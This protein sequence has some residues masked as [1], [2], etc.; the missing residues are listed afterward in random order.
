M[1]DLKRPISSIFYLIGV[2]AVFFTQIYD[3]SGWIVIINYGLLA[4]LVGLLI[5]NLV[6]TTYIQYSDGLV[7][8]NRQFFTKTTFKSVDIEEIS[9][10][11]PPF[12]RSYFRLKDGS[13]IKFDSWMIS[14]KDTDKLK[15]INPNIS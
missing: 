10:E 4:G 12:T 1:V 11:Y 9:I 7:I 15:L 2:I 3:S 5:N 8:I 13:K 6:N 14:K